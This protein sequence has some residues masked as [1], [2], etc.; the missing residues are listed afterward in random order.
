MFIYMFIFLIISEVSCLHLRGE[1]CSLLPVFP[2]SLVLSWPLEVNIPC[3]SFIVLYIK[4]SLLKL[5]MWFLSS[6]WT[7]TNM[8]RENHLTSLN[9]D[10]FCYKIEIKLK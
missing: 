8:L 10:S 9:L 7:L 5:L 2:H 6:D 1:D 3:D 4:L